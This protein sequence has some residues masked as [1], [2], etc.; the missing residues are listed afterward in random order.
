MLS[1][2]FSQSPS[3]GDVRAQDLNPKGPGGDRH[4]DGDGDGRGPEVL[5]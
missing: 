4:A 2:T 5:A 1:Q 3:R